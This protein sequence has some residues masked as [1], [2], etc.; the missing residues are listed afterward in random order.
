MRQTEGLKDGP[1]EEGEGGRDGGLWSRE[2]LRGS[3]DCLRVKEE[4]AFF[5]LLTGSYHGPGLE[6][7][8]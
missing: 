6:F 4:L 1:G 5:F 2:E 7:A 8:L 3:H